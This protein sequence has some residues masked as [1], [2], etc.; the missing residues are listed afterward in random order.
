MRKIVQAHHAAKAQLKRRRPRPP[1][2]QVM[3][4]KKKRTKKPRKLIFISRDDPKYKHM[5]EM[6]DI[7]KDNTEN[8]IKELQ[9]EL[10]RLN[11][12]VVSSDYINATNSNNNIKYHEIYSLDLQ[13]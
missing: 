6:M 13:K 9:N 4:P 7:I 5:Q 3:K 2:P 8:A 10:K 12:K 11:G 1:V